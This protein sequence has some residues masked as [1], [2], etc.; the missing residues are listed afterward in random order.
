ME[1]TNVWQQFE[2]LPPAAKRQVAELIAFLSARGER[3]PP[4]DV[5]LD[6]PLAEEGFVGIWRDRDE[7]T[8]STGWVR[9][10]RTEEWGS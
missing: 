3:Q 8:D 5:V 7:L 6:K 1:M 2:A 9:R 10:L 4:G